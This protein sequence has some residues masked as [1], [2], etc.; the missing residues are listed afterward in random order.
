MGM[1]AHPFLRRVQVLRRWQKGKATYREVFFEGKVLLTIR[2]GIGPD[3]AAAAIRN[4]DFSPA[5][6]V[7]AGTAGS[8]VADLKR[9]DL[10]VSSETLFAHEPASVLESPFDLVHALTTACCGEHL[11]HRVARLAT[12]TRAVFSLEERRLLHTATAAH[13]VDME[14]HA[15]S[16]EASRLSV[17]FASL[18][19]ISDDFA[20]PPLPDRRNFRQIWK[21][22]G[23]IPSELLKFLQWATF[24]RDFRRAAEVLQPVLVRLIRNNDTC[25]LPVTEGA[26][27][28]SPRHGDCQQ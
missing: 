2:C 15:M 3:K 6:V 19:V 28:N 25:G 26:S 5:A 7:C 23:S 22:P 14:S 8:L 12:V 13:G 9:G 1:E 20:S 21:R 17:P 11:P 27:G 10:I 16:L 24:L 4:V 18:R